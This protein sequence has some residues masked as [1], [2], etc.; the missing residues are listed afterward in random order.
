MKKIS[1]FFLFFTSLARAD[2]STSI[3]QSIANPVACTQSGSWSVNSTGTSTVNQ[4]TSPWVSSCSQSGTWNINNLSGTVSL[5]TGAATS[6]L[7]TTG[8][9]SLSTIASALTLASGSTTSGQTGNMTMGAVSTSLPTYTNGQTNY[10]SLTPSGA[11]RVD[12]SFTTQPVS[13]TVTANQGGAPWS[14]NV[15]QFGGTNI[16]TGTGASGTGIPRVT[17]SNDS[18]VLLWD[19]TETAA[20]AAASTPPLSSDTGLTVSNRVGLMAT[21]AASITGLA[22]ASSATDIFT[23]TGSSSK[24]IRVT[25]IRLSG[26]E[27]SP[28]AVD[29]YLIKRSS[30]NSGGTSTTRTAVPYDSSDSSATATVRAYSANPSSLGT[31]VGTLATERLSIAAIGSG[32]ATGLNSYLE[33]DFGDQI[34]KP[35]VLRGT[36]QVLAI[37]LNGVTVTQSLFDIWIEWTEE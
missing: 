14:E 12:S 20:I 32:G 21:Y 25:K 13:G 34:R 18:K 10:L 5:P 29:F 6:A 36:S 22:S 16:S 31:A 2:I 19:G 15:T 9:T 7:Q 1:L 28:G 17:V 30:A 24:T 23:I 11:L 37:N 35:V 8:N 33:W 4:G 3:I 26:T 27:S